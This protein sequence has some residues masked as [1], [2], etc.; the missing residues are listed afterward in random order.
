MNTIGRSTRLPRDTYIRP[1]IQVA[2]VRLPPLDLDDMLEVS[3]LIG[4]P[5]RNSFRRPTRS[6]PMRSP[7]HEAAI[8]GVTAPAKGNLSRRRL[9]ERYE[10]H[11]QGGEG[12]SHELLSNHSFVQ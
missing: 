1:A 6:R 3:G 9:S 5:R 8:I 12:Y 2:G 4:G 7:S 10:N 11:A